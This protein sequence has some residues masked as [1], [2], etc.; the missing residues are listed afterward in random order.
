MSKKVV[1]KAAH[2]LLQVPTR[3]TITYGNILTITY[4]TILVT[5]EEAGLANAVSRSGNAKEAL[6]GPFLYVLTIIAAILL[7]WRTSLSGIIAVSAMAAGDGVSIH[8]MIKRERCTL[9]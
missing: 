2:A 9:I 4:G 3:T 7:F 1:L 8:G 6:G 5:A